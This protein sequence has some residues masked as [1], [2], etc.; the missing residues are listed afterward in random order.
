METNNKYEELLNFFHFEIRCN[1]V[2][3]R[4]R[5]YVYGEEYRYTNISWI[6]SYINIHTNYIS[7]S[8]I[9]DC[10]IKESDFERLSINKFISGDMCDINFKC[11]CVDDMEK[12]LYR[13]YPEK[14][15]YAKLKRII[16]E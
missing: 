13:L 6:D 12:Y 5:Y 16:Y 9:K 15:R 2:D 4:R 11:F 10:K 7:G 1:D 8:M 3:A 14:L